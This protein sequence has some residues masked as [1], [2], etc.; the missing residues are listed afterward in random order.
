TATV[1]STRDP[2]TGK[3]LVDVI[4]DTAGQKGTGKWAT[5]EAAELGSPATAIEAA[6]T[7]RLIAANRSARQ[8][9]AAIYADRAPPAMRRQ[10][11]QRAMIDDLEKALL[12]SKVVAYAQ[13]FGVMAAASQEWKWNLPLGT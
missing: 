5:M 12:A 8:A 3:P 6:V 7:A 4:R 9:A 13:G 2:D 1:L 11:D 10:S